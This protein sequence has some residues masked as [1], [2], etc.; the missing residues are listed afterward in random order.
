VSVSKAGELTPPEKSAPPGTAAAN[1]ASTNGAG[2]SNGHAA[3]AAPRARA[4]SGVE[5]DVRGEAVEVWSEQDWARAT[6]LFQILDESGHADPAAV[7]ALAPEELRRM[8]AGMLRS[9][10][11]DQRLLPLQRQGR[12]GF[13]IGATG[14]EAG[15][16]AGAHALG[17]DDWFV[18]GLRE[19]SAAL[20]RGFPLRTHLAQLF[21]NANDLTH[22]RQMPCHSGSRASKHLIMSSC[23][24]SQLPHAVGLAMAARISGDKAVVLGYLGDGGT[25]EEDFHVA[26]NFAAVFKAPVVFVCQNNQW[27][28]ST[29]LS[30]QTASDTIAQKGLAYGMPSVRV[31][32][33]DL[34][35][36]YATIKEAVERARAGGGPT[37]IEA[38]TY[39]LGPHS[40]SDDPTRYRDEAEPEA[41]RKKDPLVR[42]RIWL[43]ATG[44][45]APEAEA[46]LA[47][48]LEREI[49]EGIVLE[50]AAPPPPLRSMIEDVTAQPS[51][52][53]EEQL[54]EL[55]RVRGRR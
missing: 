37:F 19:S 2:A 32:G 11:L 3:P 44:V 5:A 18:P 39:R 34:L 40:S 8:Y 22:G 21:G 4:R 14:Q 49:R 23:V 35:A 26:L 33:N 9:R 45:L 17:V 7:P 10:L 52:I 12:I 27:A 29:P 6:G 36:M 41:W 53:L 16:I 30:L 38:L 51:W 55:E 15:I 31:D 25:S 54:A 1:G 28:I 47:E 42:L 48:E 43:A 50:E 46:R 13:Y 24:S 20:Y